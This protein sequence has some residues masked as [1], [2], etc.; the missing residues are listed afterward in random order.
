M[1]L[2]DKCIN[3]TLLPLCAASIEIGTTTE[4]NQGLIV[5]FK[6]LTTGRLDM[7]AATSDGAGLIVVDVTPI[8]FMEGHK[9]EITVTRD[10]AV[11]IES[12]VDL[13]VGAETNKC[14]SVC[15]TS[16]SGILNPVIAL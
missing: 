4:L 11:G 5:Y 1:S 16:G 14:I 12:T 10:D 8:T 13:T 2:C 15:F 3:A 7:L 9:Y 6:N